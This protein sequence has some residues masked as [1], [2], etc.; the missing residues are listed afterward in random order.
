MI[1]ALSVKL[2]LVLTSLA[3][4]D[5]CLGLD[6]ERSIYQ[7]NCRNWTRDSGL[8]SNGVRGIA[9]SED[10]YL[11][12]G[13]SKGIAYFDGISF[14]VVEPS[15]DSALA[16]KVITSLAPRKGG[17]IWLGTEGACLGFYDNTL[18]QQFGLEGQLSSDST[19]RTLL[20]TG[21]G[22]LLLGTVFGADFLNFKTGK[23]EELPFDPPAEVFAIEEGNDGRIWLGTAARGVLLW[24]DGVLKEVEDRW[25]KGEVVV[26]L[27]VDKQDQLWVGTSAGLRLYDSEL[28]RLEL[29]LDDF[30]EVKSILVDRDGAVWI[31]TSGDGLFRY[32][33][34]A[35]SVLRETDG[36]ASDHIYA[37]SESSDGSIWV[38]SS[39]GLSQLSAYRFPT[40]SDTEGLPHEGALSVACAPG[41]GI[42]VGTPNGA[43]FYK[44]GAF[45]NYGQLEADN[46]TSN[47]IKYVFAAKSG[48]VFFIGASRN[49]D[50]FEDGKVVKS[51]SFDEWPRRLVEDDCGIILAV[52]GKLYRFE[53]G[54]FV[55]YQFKEGEREDFRWI[56]DLAYTDDGTLWVGASTGL[57]EI[58][59]GIVKDLFALNGVPSARCSELAF[60][61]E[62]SVWIAGR[63]GL[64]RCKNGIIQM[65]D[66]RY[67]LPRFFINSIVPDQRGTFWLD[68][69]Q[70]IV[71]IAESELIAAIEKRSETLAFKLYE[72]QDALRTT[73]KISYE[74]SGCMTDDG[75]I[76]FPSSEGIVQIDSKASFGLRPPPPVLITKALVDG[77]VYD[78]S[79]RPNLKPGSR[80]LQIDYLALDY[81]APRLIQYRYRLLGFDDRWVEADTRRTAYYTNLGPGE[82][83]F[84]VQAANSGGGWAEAGTGLSLVFPPRFYEKTTF[85][86]LLALGVLFLGGYMIWAYNVRQQQVHLRFAHDQL[87]VSVAERTSEL[88]N[89]NRDLR[90][91]VEQRKQAQKKAEILQAEMLEAVKRAQLAVEAKSQFL[92]NMSHEIRTPM[93]A[94]IGFNDLMLCTDLDGEQMEFAETIRSASESLLSILN[95]ILDFSKMEAGKLQMEESEF[96]LDETIEDTVNLVSVRAAEKGLDI[97][98]FIER[99]L[100]RYWIGDPLRLRQVLIN[101]LGNGVKFTDRGSV[102]ISVKK[103]PSS[104]DLYTLRFEVADTGIGVSTGGEGQLFDP[105]FQ[106]DN[107]N[108]RKH[109]GTGLGLA[110][111]RQIVETMGGSIGFDSSPDLGSTFHFS[112]PLKQSDRLKISS[113]ALKLN[114]VRVLALSRS[115]LTRKTLSHFADVFSMRLVLV[116]SEEEAYAAMAKKSGSA[117]S[118]AI[119][120]SEAFDGSML[121]LSA[122]LARAA[123]LPG[124]GLAL[125]NIVCS[126]ARVELRDPEEA[127]LVTIIRKP[128]FQDEFMRSCIRAKVTHTRA[129]MGKSA[130]TAQ[131]FSH[132]AL[133]R[134]IEN[135]D[136]LVAED[137]DNNR[138]L[139]QVMLE[140]MGCTAEIT[141]NGLAALDA[142]KRRPFDIVLMDCQMPVLDGY[143]A[144]RRI[145]STDSMSDT[146]VVAMT[147]NAMVGDR[148]KCIAAGMD[149]Y[150]PKPINS[151]KLKLILLEAY[152]RKRTG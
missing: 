50:L 85:R 63:D 124:V 47:W 52:A 141:V 28:R 58:K 106:G 22:D 46:F 145:R 25:A 80:N 42:W 29:P 105:F 90:I 53:G 78:L 2:W 98:V 125:L 17:G 48:E 64:A 121:E 151:E 4:S 88:G 32:Y 149:D 40:Y 82:Y 5:L 87:E 104:K 135:L 142:L 77:E 123:N 146:F 107:S 126:M 9:L 19:V 86:V 93:N 115:A 65:M 21:D 96:D 61:G 101:L 144:T 120:D 143:E 114:G 97:A 75:S 81:V 27:G 147:A 112:I 89:A 35:F 23:I 6:P 84:E 51:W 99:D 118:F 103:G 38:G 68:T 24:E 60:D 111:C 102:Q 140:K 1:R 117:F 95:D 130:P 30:P 26:A 91:E 20:Q 70:G 69:N 129:E 31:G 59:D 55:P 136:V 122:R 62:G 66:T 72:G 150:L 148:E 108:T 12:L 8:P 119:V 10:G 7:Y 132:L 110:I 37:L 128:I 71:E 100:P 79:S 41:G 137:N 43:S 18:F 44:D 16:G 36:L 11:W 109:G 13:T 133:D 67:E 56:S 94:I 76:W 152:R 116:E 131:A 57:F 14:H 74:H 127:D 45:S 134:R 54:E 113:E 34:G 92:A 73:E 83:R 3:C 49:L 139:I 15:K 33:E 138:I 39:K